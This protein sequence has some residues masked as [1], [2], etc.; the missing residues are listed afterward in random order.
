MRYRL[1]VICKDYFGYLLLIMLF[2]FYY[3]YYQEFG[4]LLL[5]CFIVILLSVVCR[6]NIKTIRLKC[7]FCLLHQ[8]NIA[9]C[10]DVKRRRH[11]SFHPRDAT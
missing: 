10:N 9:D 2:Y 7:S 8:D 6:I 11:S 1:I 5:T 4:Q 3:Y